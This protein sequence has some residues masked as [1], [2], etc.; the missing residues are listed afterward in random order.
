MVKRS[1]REKHTRVIPHFFAVFIPLSVE[2]ARE[3]TMGIPAFAS[4]FTIP[5]GCL[6]VQ[7]MMHCDRSIP[8]RIA[9]PTTLSTVVYLPASLLFTMH[10]FPLKSTE[11]WTAPVFRHTSVSISRVTVTTSSGVMR[12]SDEIIPGSFRILKPSDEPI[13]FFYRDTSQPR[14]E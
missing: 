7:P 9:C 3:I 11:Q 8:F 4:F 12:I 1:P 6:P 10:F 2:A 13:V 5:A 14:S